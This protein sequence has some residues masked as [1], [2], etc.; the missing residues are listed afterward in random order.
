MEKLSAAVNAPSLQEDMGKKKNA[1]KKKK[2]KKNGN[3]LFQVYLPTCT[4]N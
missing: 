2:T 4:C 3:I 1:F